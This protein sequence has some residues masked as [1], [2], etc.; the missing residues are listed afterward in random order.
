[1]KD[2]ERRRR[3]AGLRRHPSVSLPGASGLD[4]RGVLQNELPFAALPH[5][6]HRQQDLCGHPHGAPA[7]G[8]FRPPCFCAAA[9]PCPPVT[10]AWRCWCIEILQASNCTWLDLASGKT[11]PSPCWLVKEERGWACNNTGMDNGP[12]TIAGP[13]LEQ[14][15]TVTMWLGTSWALG[16]RV[17]PSTQPPLHGAAH[18]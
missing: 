10:S 18:G 2:V 12:Y 15:D 6:E 7:T 5:V 13:T 9:L 16:P 14:G 11:C 3:S 17:C 8:S 4:C 1:M